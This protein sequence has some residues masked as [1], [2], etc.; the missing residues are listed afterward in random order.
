MYISIISIILSAHII[1]GIAVRFRRHIL[2][3][4]I[5]FYMLLLLLLFLQ[6]SI[7]LST[8]T[9][10]LY[11]C[12][13]NARLNCILWIATAHSDL[14]LVV[15]EIELLDNLFLIGLVIAYQTLIEYCFFLT[16]IFSFFYFSLFIFLLF[17][18]LYLFSFFLY[19]FFLFLFYLIFSF[20]I[21]FSFSV[22]CT[23]LFFSFY[24]L[25][26]FFITHSP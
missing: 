18:F 11:Q 1:T 21:Y 10:E 2:I 16:C 14:H 8:V 4:S 24:S 22:K 7:Q 9:I 13:D 25:F 15:K 20:F 17:F 19:L 26:F 5:L 12:L 6:C 3:N 23:Y